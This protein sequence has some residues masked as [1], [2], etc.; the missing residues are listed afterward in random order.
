LPLLK[1]RGWEIRAFSRRQAADTDQGIQ[2]IRLAQPVHEG[3]SSNGTHESI[4]FWICAAPLWVLPD[5]FPMLEKH[6]VRRVVALSSTSRFTKQDSS[7]S[8]EQFVARRL[9][10]AEDGFQAWAEDK[11]VSWVI[12]RP[13]MVYG[14]GRDRNISEIIRLIRRFNF[15]PLVGRAGGFRQ[16]VHAED[17][18]MACLSALE[19]TEVVNHAYNLSGGETLHY[20]EMIERLFT[21][22]GRRP[23]LIPIPIKVFG[24]AMACIHCLPRYRNWNAQM[25]QRMVV[26]LVF[27]HTEAM[28]DFHYSPR[29]FKLTPKDIP[30]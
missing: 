15:F 2:R 12:L 13:T 19:T 29:P 6:G 10:E 17:V 9:S 5:Y 26:D 21:A 7:A 23:R 20:R 1:Q 24:W 16:P 30:Q 8:E 11:G 25:A 18:A 14:L 3:V 28:R 22:I 27:D 4:A